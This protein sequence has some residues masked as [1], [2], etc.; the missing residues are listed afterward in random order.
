MASGPQLSS[1]LQVDS[2][3]AWSPDGTTIAFRGGECE[4]VFDDCL[5]VGEVASGRERMVAAY[6]GG[7][8]VRPGFAVIPAWRPDGA[9]L[10]WTG[11]VDGGPL[12]VTEAAADGAARRQVGV[13]QDREMTY[14]DSRTGV[15][16]SQHQGG[17]WVTLVNLR[18]G[19]RSYLVKGSQPDAQD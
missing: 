4:S 19:A 14:H 8:E 16:T 15:L 5:T 17:S 13:G 7:P 1:R 12:G 10:S 3:V 6:G 9:K 11:A 18:T 2:A